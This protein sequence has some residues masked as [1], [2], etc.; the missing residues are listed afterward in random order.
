MASEPRP[1]VDWDVPRVDTQADITSFEGGALVAEPGT[2]F[3]PASIRATVVQALLA[4]TIVLYVVDVAQSV[5]GVILLSNLTN[6]TMDQVEAFD[7][8]VALVAQATVVLFVVTAIAFLAWQHRAVS[9]VPALGGGK[10][11]V[12]PN[13]SVGWWFVPF[14]N[15]VKPYQIVSD[16]WQR[17]ATSSSRTGTGLVLAWWVTYIVGNLLGYLYGFQRPATTVEAFNGRMAFNIVDDVIVI[18]AGVLAFAVVR[19]IERRSAARAAAIAAAPHVREAGAKAGPE[20]AP[21][22]E[23]SEPAPETEGI[24]PA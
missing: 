5:Y 6:V 1:V 24:E 3:R 14:A 22:D 19:E 8:T 15:L 11:D 13:A 20:H 21:E 2:R 10:T 23:A 18:A 7:R 9:N 16:V 12:S 17:L 4:L